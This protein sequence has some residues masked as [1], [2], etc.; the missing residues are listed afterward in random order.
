VESMTQLEDGL[1]S[2]R[3]GS[4]PARDVR[5]RHRKEFFFALQNAIRVGIAVSAGA[6]FLVLAGWPASALA[7][8]ITAIVCA[9]STT[10]PDPSKAVVAAIASF[11]LAAASA[12]IVHFY[13]LTDSQDFIR[14]AIA[15]APTI[16][17]GCLL[18]VN[19]KIA[20]IGVMINT[21]F[22]FVLVPSN[23]QSFNAL[24]FFSQCMFVAF[25]LAVVFLASRL[26]WPASELDKQRAVVRATKET[27]LAS[28]TG[29]KYS[30]QAL[31]IALASRIADYVAAATDRPHPEV[32]KGLLGTNDLS[33]ASAAAY[34]HLEQSSDDPAIRSRLGPLQRALQSGNSRRLYAGAR[35]ILRRMQEGNAG[36]QEA[37]LAA[38]TDLWSA[39]LVLEHERHGIRP[40]NGRGFI[41][42]GEGR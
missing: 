20:G 12:D 6:V 41:T 9:L 29:K 40:F 4:E 11:A 19:P 35:S 23:P 39:G 7:L 5:F 8:T 37:L 42:G 32:L 10:M 2:L 33:L 28:V 34:A 16:L 14:L 3:E 25:A 13:F 31:S 36:L 15:I 27:L 1:L 17:F 22:F 26:V 38:V 24:S 21:I 18:S 30:P